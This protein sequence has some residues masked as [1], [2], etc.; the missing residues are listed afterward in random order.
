[1][2][3]GQLQDLKTRFKEYAKSFY[4]DDPDSQKNIV[5][6]ENHTFE[7][8]K[9][10]NRIAESLKLKEDEINLAEAIALFHDIGR[11]EQLKRY[12]TFKDSISVNHG[13]LGAQILEETKVLN[14]L[15]HEESQIIIQSVKFHNAIKMPDLKDARSILHL[16]LIRDADKLDI[17]RI[18][19]AYFL[20]NEDM[21]SAAGLGL[22]DTAGYNKDLLNEIY[23]R[24]IVPLSNVKNLNDFK[25]MQT[26]WV[27]DLN[28]KES[29]QIF[30]ER[31]YIDTLS[32][33][34]DAE[35]ILKVKEF[36]MRYIDER[37]RNA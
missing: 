31:H 15:P 4:T 1:M 19:K 23:S 14:A 28:Y 9:N 3:K 27:F 10:I 7:V 24:K 12:K 35:D 29:Y 22:P 32:S 36:I 16:K 33:I 18:F 21:G 34:S 6:K 2:N 25:I 13:L 26:S 8:C 37:I 20:D 17:W 11:F 5:L 30:K